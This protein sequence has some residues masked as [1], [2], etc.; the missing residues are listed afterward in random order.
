[1]LLV[2]LNT[3][4][5]IS[6][7]EQSGY[8][9]C[10]KGHII[11]IGCRSP[12]PQAFV[13]HLDCHR[14]LRTAV[15]SVTAAHIIQFGQTVSSDLQGQGFSLEALLV[16][17]TIRWYLLEIL[18]SLFGSKLPPPEV[19]DM[20]FRHIDSGPGLSLAIVLGETV[21]TLK[22]MLSNPMP[23]EGNNFKGH[24]NLDQIP[25]S[26]I[27]ILGTRYLCNFGHQDL[28]ASLPCQDLITG[29]RVAFD[30]VGIRMLRFLMT[31]GSEVKI[32]EE[33]RYGPPM[34]YAFFRVYQDDLTGFNCWCDVRE[35]PN[36]A[37]RS[38]AS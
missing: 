5:Q 29:M 14:A 35:T 32:L 10:S 37:V 31:D 15:P 1:M 13:C 8:E 30:E 34:W 38:P 3:S 18:G 22:R 26:F 9:Y 33:S 2:H 21:D 12:S 36:R 17:N 20:I 24:Y 19:Q 16:S 7:D 23:L 4:H 25:L 6:S 27:H 11:C 28:P